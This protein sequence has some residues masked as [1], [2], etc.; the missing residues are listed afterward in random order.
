MENDWKKLFKIETRLHY[1]P[2]MGAIKSELTQLRFSLYSL[3]RSIAFL[4]GKHRRLGGGGVASL[5]DDM[6]R[7]ILEL[8]MESLV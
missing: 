5:S 8:T 3:P 1:W 4:M 6:C 2:M 7:M